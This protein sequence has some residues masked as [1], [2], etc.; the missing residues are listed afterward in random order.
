MVINDILGREVGIVADG[1]KKAGTHWIKYD[2]SSLPSGIYFYTLTAGNFK[3]T[4]KMLL[5][6]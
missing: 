4:K 5:V 2:A 3:E 1:F 6:K